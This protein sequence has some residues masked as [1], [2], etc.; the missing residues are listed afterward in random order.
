MRY[1]CDQFIM[2]VFGQHLCINVRAKYFKKM[3]EQNAVV[4]SSSTTMII[5]DYSTDIG[6]S[7]WLILT[8]LNNMD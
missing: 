1:F 4:L 2:Y 6:K 3:L 7:W 8:S 5:D